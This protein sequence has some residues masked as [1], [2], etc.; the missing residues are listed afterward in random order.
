MAGLITVVT[1]CYNN[2]AG[3]ESTAHSLAQQ[4]FRAFEWIV[5]DG[6][7][8]DGTVEYLQSMQRD[9]TWISESDRGIYDAMR[10]GLAIAS[11]DYVLFLNAGDELVDSVS[12]STL[13]PHLDGTDVLF[14]D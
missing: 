14:L 10:K 11:G 9:C 1:I 4:E 6:A 3:L 7:S 2:I 12:L 5:I 8:R 13:V